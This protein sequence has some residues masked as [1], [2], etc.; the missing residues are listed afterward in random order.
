MSYEDDI[1]ELIEIK[2]R[3]WQELKKQEALFG[4]KTDPGVLIEIRDI[5]VDIQEMQ[6]NLGKAIVNLSTAPQHQAQSH[7]TSRLESLRFRDIYHPYETALSQLLQDL[8]PDHSRYSDAIT[9]QA[10][11]TLIINQSRR[12]GNTQSRETAF[13]EVIDQL[14]ELTLSTLGL[15]FH[16][17]MEQ[18]D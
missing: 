4:K 5:E 1:R 18:L 17:L 6:T 9:Y 13:A 8:G 16:E 12:Y 15:S 7:S 2:Y 11:L 3:R 14:N 10:R